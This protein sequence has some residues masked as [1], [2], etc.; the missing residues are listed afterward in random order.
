MTTILVVDDELLYR[1]L[2]QVNLEKEGYL[3]TTAVNGENALEI[4][5]HEEPDMILLDLIM[6]TLDGFSTCERIR[7]FSNVPII[8]LTARTSE[9]DRVHGL[10]IGADDY[11]AKPFSATELVARV[12]AIL[13]RSRNND[14]SYQNRF[15]DHGNLRIDYTRAEV[16]NDNKTIMLSATEYRLL[17]QLAQNIGQVLTTEDL[18]KSIWG[19]QYKDDKEILWVT[20]AR[21]R[22][23]L[24]NNPHTPIHILTRPGIGYYMPVREKN[25]SP[26]GQNGGTI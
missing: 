6:P 2:L 16:T 4:L 20:I 17:I 19:V 9:Q 23:K 3:V 10:N 22:Q 24:E 18:L 7:Q 15:F 26:G 25:N 14:H 11:V 5:S 12:R 1:K 21:L 13:R 8:I